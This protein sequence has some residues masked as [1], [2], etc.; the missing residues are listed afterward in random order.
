MTHSQKIKFLL[1]QKISEHQLRLVHLQMTLENN[2]G[3]QFLYNKVEKRLQ[4]S[5]KR[6]QTRNPR[7]LY[8]L[9]YTYKTHILQKIVFFVGQN[10]INKFNSYI[11][12]VVTNF[13]YDKSQIAIEKLCHRLYK[14][15]KYVNTLLIEDDLFD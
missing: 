10:I 7:K 4:Y 3:P 9:L 8:K 11:E 13:D 5:H 2:Q 12:D 1:N 6:V 15:D 14:I